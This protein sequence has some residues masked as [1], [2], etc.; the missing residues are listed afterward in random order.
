MTRAAE[1]TGGDQGTLLTRR[2]RAGRQKEGENQKRARKER[3]LGRPRLGF[4]GPRRGSLGGL[5]GGV[6]G[7]T[8]AGSLWTP[9]WEQLLG[10]CHC[11]PCGPAGHREPVSSTNSAQRRAEKRQ[12]LP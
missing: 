5:P 10:H 8:Q 1:A 11:P 7:C 3:D 12:L 6:V 4:A 9:R 2:R